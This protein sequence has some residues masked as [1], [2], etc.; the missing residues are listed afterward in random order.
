MKPRHILRQMDD[1]DAN[2]V[3]RWRHD[4][5]YDFYDSTADPTDPAELLHQERRRGVYFSV[6]DGENRLTGFFQFEKFERRDGTVEV[7]LGLR[8]DLTGKGPGAGFV[9]S[10]R[11]FAR[12]AR[13][14]F[15]PQRFTPSGTTFDERAIGA[16]ERVG[17]RR[18]EVYTHETN[19]GEYEFLP[20]WRE[21]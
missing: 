1:A 4:P 17:F 14:R 8:P 18:G 5:P 6:L 12:A 16:Y 10:G 9:L 19:G 7:G 20:M 21:A 15:S 11:A 13:A 2:E 3:A